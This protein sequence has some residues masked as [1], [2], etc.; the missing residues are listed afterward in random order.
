METTKTD[1]EIMRET[2][3]THLPARALTTKGLVFTDN[4]EGRSLRDV[5]DRAIEV[6]RGLAG[7]P[8]VRRTG[9][10]HLG[11]LASLI[12]W[13]NRFKGESSALYLDIVPPLAQTATAINGGGVAVAG[14]SGS[15]SMTETTTK[16]ATVRV[17]GSVQLISIANYHA[18]GAPAGEGEDSTAQHCDHRGVYDF[19]VSEAWKRWT[20]AADEPMTVA[21]FG[22]FI[23]DN[24]RD[25]LDPTAFILNGDHPVGDDEDP[26]SNWEINA[27]KI[28]KRL[29][30]DFASVDRMIDLGRSFNVDVET[31]VS[32]KVDRQSKRP[33]V[34]IDEQHTDGQ[35][36]ELRL[37]RLFL[38]S[39]PVFERGDAYPIVCTFNYRARGPVLFFS[40][41]DAQAAFDDAVDE[42][43]A[44]AAEKTELPLLFGTPEI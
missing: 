35:G 11:T 5:T 1:S 34:L 17:P 44:T 22:A 38:I 33:N 24:A 40:L 7:L 3:E 32:V 25:L 14:D 9:T 29:K 15:I 8:P 13:T 21:E 28:A 20:G 41:Y 27:R 10:A 19:P 43:A 23:E 16:T 6:E 12:D 42:V 37:P 36:E 31:K 30:G 18:A 39:V 26:V 2:V 4:C